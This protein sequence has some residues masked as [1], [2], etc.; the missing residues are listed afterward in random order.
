L[1]TREVLPRPFHDFKVIKDFNLTLQPPRECPRVALGTRLK[2]SLLQKLFFLQGEHRERSSSSVHCRLTSVCCCLSTF[3]I[4]PDSA[5][6]KQE[7]LIPHWQVTL[8]NPAL[9]IS[10]PIL[11]KAG[12]LSEDEDA[13]LQP[14]ADPRNNCLVGFSTLTTIHCPCGPRFSAQFLSAI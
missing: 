2:Y 10:P 11:R 6:Q 7:N 8:H 1:A 4:R 14:A 3:D 12:R 5:C 13:C 9:R